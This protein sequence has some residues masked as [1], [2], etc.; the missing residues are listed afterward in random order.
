MNKILKKMIVATLIFCLA[1][2]NVRVLKANNNQIRHFEIIEITEPYIIKL[3]KKFYISDESLLSKKIGYETLETLKQ[4]LKQQNSEISAENSR[5]AVGN[6]HIEAYRKIGATVERHFWGTRIKTHNRKQT[7][8]AR[9]LADVFAGRSTIESMATALASIGVPPLSV[10]LGA[11]SFV[12]GLDATTWGKVVK[13]IG[14]RMLYDG[15]DTVTIDI[16]G[17]VLNVVVY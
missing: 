12:A 2:S 8:A 10:V 5:D 14:D 9:E 13:G 15:K 4:F 17:W 3:N 7:L 6:V 16:N 1:F 11:W